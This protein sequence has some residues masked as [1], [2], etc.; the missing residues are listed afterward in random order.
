MTF[1]QTASETTT[2]I[3]KFTEEKKKVTFDDALLTYL[4]ITGVVHHTLQY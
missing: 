1:E 4:L 2:F 3:W